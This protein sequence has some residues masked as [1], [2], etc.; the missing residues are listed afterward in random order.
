MKLKDLIEQE[1]DYPIK[2]KVGFARSGELNT[3]FGRSV[4]SDFYRFYRNPNLDNKPEGLFTD[5]SMAVYEKFPETGD[6]L[7][8]INDL[9]MEFYKNIGD[10][11]A[12]DLPGNYDVKADETVAEYLFSKVN[13]I[14]ITSKD[15]ISQIE[16]NGDFKALDLQRI[17]DALEEMNQKLQGPAP[18]TGM[19]PVGFKINKMNEMKKSQL[20][21]IIKESIKELMNEQPANPNGPYPP[22][23]DPL[24]WVTQ[25]DR[26]ISPWAPECQKVQRSINNSNSASTTA[27][28]KRRN[29]LMYKMEHVR[30]CYC[31]PATQPSCI[32]GPY[33]GCPMGQ[34]C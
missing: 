6:Q 32:H 30:D 29:M 23:F 11:K 12:K 28:P 13:L 26:R 9:A 5:M 8:N 25:Y 3:D 33:A 1:L 22:N 19:E 17:E 21:N 31:G 34:G 24:A 10:P 7:A 14:N 15:I 16:E 4:T 27:G 18:T 20:K 2:K